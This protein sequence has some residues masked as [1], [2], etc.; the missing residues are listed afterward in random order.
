MPQV[1]GA[2]DIG[3]VGQA[4]LWADSAFYQGPTGDISEHEFPDFLEANGFSR[5]S[6][7]NPQQLALSKGRVTFSHLL[8]NKTM[9]G[10]PP[11]TN[12]ATGQLLNGD[13]Y[14]ELVIHHDPNIDEGLPEGK[15]GKT[16]Y[17]LSYHHVDRNGVL[18]PQTIMSTNRLGPLIE[19]HRQIRSAMERM[20]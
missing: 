15:N 8:G 9:G 2:D 1:F 4:S 3:L 7:L 10:K 17:E 11:R 14:H 13:G 20:R 16:R 18:H 6:S 12:P 5:G 19:K